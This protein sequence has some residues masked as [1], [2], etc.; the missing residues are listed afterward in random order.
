M[1]KTSVYNKYFCFSYQLANLS[2]LTVNM[3]I[4][5][6]SSRP[7]LSI[8]LLS[9]D[10][11]RKPQEKEKGHTYKFPSSSKTTPATT[12]TYNPFFSSSSSSSYSTS[13]RSSSSTSSN[14]LSRPKPSPGSKYLARCVLT[15]N[16]ECLYNKYSVNK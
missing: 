13:F 8:V 11:F 12:M 9:G 3:I 15:V 2:I 6:F 5:S 7:F 16:E 14:Q 10:T 4:F 1:E